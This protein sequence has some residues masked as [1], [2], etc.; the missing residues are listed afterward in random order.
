MTREPLLKGKA[1]YGWPPHENSLFCKKGKYL[2]SFEKSS[3]ELADPSPFY[4]NI[5]WLYFNKPRIYKYLRASTHTHTQ[6]VY[7]NTHAQ[8]NMYFH[9]HARPNTC[10]FTH[11]HNQTHVFSYTRTTKHI[12]MSVCL[13]AYLSVCLPI[14][15]PACPPT[16]LSID[17]FVYQSI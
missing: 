4:W 17:L 12:Y 3:Y 7:F 16:Y 9:T 1:Q 6:Y 14:C 10:I 15:L 13:S 2:F 8:A 11:T 5:I